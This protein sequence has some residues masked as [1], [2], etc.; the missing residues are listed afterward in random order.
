MQIF[1]ITDLLVLAVILRSDHIKLI[2]SIAKLSFNIVAFF[3]SRFV[4]RRNDNEI[5]R[6]ENFLSLNCAVSLADYTFYA[7]SCYG[8]SVL[9]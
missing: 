4:F 2:E 5:S 3:V 6:L 8:S 9:F 7:V 1:F